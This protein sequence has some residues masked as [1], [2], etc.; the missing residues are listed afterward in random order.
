MFEN[1][2][3]ARKGMTKVVTLILGTSCEDIQATEPLALLRR[4]HVGGEVAVLY[5]TTLF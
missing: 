3:L 2:G 5:A 1:W 4:G